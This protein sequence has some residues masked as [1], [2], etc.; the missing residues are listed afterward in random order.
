MNYSCDIIDFVNYYCYIIDFVNYSSYIID[1]V[2]IPDDSRTP[3]DSYFIL[4][5]KKKIDKDAMN[6]IQKQNRKYYVTIQF[7]DRQN[8]EC[9]SADSFLGIH[10][11]DVDK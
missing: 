9:V 5:E 10:N 8:I 11:I 2:S 3:L 6:D 1:F 4:E 7:E